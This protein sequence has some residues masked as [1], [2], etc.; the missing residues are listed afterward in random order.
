MKLQTLQAWWRE[1]NAK[2]F[3]G[4]LNPCPIRIT[5]SRRYWGHFSD[6][7]AIYLGRHLNRTA[8]EFRD[9]LLHEMIHQHLEQQGV[10][11]PDDHG[12]RFQAEH[13]RVLGREYIEPLPD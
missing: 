6:L 10:A 1:L 13:T 5:R 8:E 12:P 9:T 4:T 2:Y 11:E 7:P 3:A